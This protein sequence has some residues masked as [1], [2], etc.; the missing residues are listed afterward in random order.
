MTSDFASEVAKCP[1]KPTKPQYPKMGISITRG[2][3]IYEREISS[4][5][6]IIIKIKFISRAVSI[7]KNIESEAGELLRKMAS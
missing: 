2:L 6:I 5:L 1:E 7:D 4:P 3:S